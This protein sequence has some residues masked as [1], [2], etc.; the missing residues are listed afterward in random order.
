MAELELES[1][2]ETEALIKQRRN[3]A[4]V[5]G[6]L[7]PEIPASVFAHAQDGWKP[8]RIDPDSKAGENAESRYKLGWMAVMH[9]ASSWRR[10]RPSF[11]SR[12]CIYG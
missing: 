5:I 7:P 9:V 11:F 2:R 4:T 8:E 3:A 6:A 12:W 1:L 10:V